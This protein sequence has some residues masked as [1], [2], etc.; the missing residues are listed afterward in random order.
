M[1]LEVCTKVPVKRIACLAVGPPNF[2]NYR[3][4]IVQVRG[5]FTIPGPLGAIVRLCQIQ[6][7]LLHDYY[8]LKI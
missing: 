3:V 6:N 4:S 8:I 7:I 2:H 1:S 5:V